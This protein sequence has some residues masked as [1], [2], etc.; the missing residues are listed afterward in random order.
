MPC[1]HICA[2]ID[3]REYYIPSMFHIRW[4]Q[5]YNYYHGSKFGKSITPTL[6]DSLTS[7]VE[8][9]RATC[10]RHSGKYKG[11]PVHGSDFL[12]ELPYCVPLDN[13]NPDPV[14][15]LV[16]R[17]KAQKNSGEPVVKIH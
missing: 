13:A 3:K 11:V 10:Y 7:V 17:I 1:L 15:D 2:V 16:L 14:F 8:V 12:E 5:V 9:T 6:Y 4:H